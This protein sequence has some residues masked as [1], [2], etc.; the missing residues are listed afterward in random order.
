[1]TWNFSSVRRI[2]NL[3]AHLAEL[4]TYLRDLSYRV[5]TSV[6]EAIG[7]TVGRIVK[8]SLQRL[9]N[10]P[11]EPESPPRPRRY[12][13][14]YPDDDWHDGRHDERWPGE[15]ADG[16]MPEP[17][18]TRPQPG[19]TPK[20]VAALSAAAMFMRA[21]GWWLCRRGSWL[22]A[23]GIGAIVG[24]VAWLG[25]P[26]IT[27]GLGFAEA[28]GELISPTVGSPSSWLL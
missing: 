13:S 24:A 18:S 5:R 17:A 11:V 3:S 19:P 25:G 2:G 6:A 23:L 9:W 14:D 8:D 21:C 7:N 4:S 16:T 22:G 27:T 12:Y 26:L 28:A 15:D 10:R 20:T 1:M